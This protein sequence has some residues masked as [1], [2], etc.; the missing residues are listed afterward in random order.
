MLGKVGIGIS[1]PK[2]THRAKFQK[3]DEMG[4]PAHHLWCRSLHRCMGGRC[5]TCSK[6]CSQFRLQGL[7]DPNL[8]WLGQVKPEHDL[9]THLSK[10]FL[11]TMTKTGSALESTG[12]CHHRPCI[13]EE[14]TGNTGFQAG[15]GHGLC[16]VLH[17]TRGHNSPKDSLRFLGKSTFQ[18]QSSSC[19][20]C[21]FCCT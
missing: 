7:Q 3:R 5:L 17:G 12:H 19:V 4:S 18:E 10:P 11:A 16:L 14:G 15:G 9:Q 20:W 2:R 13:L 8:P 21:P 6:V 1:K